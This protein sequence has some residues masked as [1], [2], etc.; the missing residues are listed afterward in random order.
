MFNSSVTGN[1]G[2]VSSYVVAKGFFLVAEG[3]FLV[4]RRSI[5]HCERNETI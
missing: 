2:E 1:V 4:T 3:F 5:C